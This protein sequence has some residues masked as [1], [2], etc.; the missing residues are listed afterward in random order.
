[1]IKN[2]H[3]LIQKRKHLLFISKSF[4]YEDYLSSIKNKLFRHVITKLD[5]QLTSYESKQEDMDKI[6][7]IELKEFVNYIILQISKMRSL[8]AI[9]SAPS[10]NGSG[11]VIYTCRQLFL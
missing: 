10:I 4:K 2:H 9:L 3:T 11:N 1:M 8:F 7:F 6:D 5:S